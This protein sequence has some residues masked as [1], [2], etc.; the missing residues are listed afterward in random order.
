MRLN[1]FLIVWLTPLI[2]GQSA[3]VLQTL[4]N[5]WTDTGSCLL[6]HVHQ[7]SHTFKESGWIHS[8]SER[9]L[10]GVVCREL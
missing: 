7:R 9:F 10:C 4:M 1:T 5:L 6:T 8:P 3:F 2:N